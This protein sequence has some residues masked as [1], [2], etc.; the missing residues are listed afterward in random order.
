MVMERMTFVTLSNGPCRVRCNCKGLWATALAIL[1]RWRSRITEPV[2]A[3]WLC[4]V[5]HGNI[6]HVMWS[7]VLPTRDLPVTALQREGR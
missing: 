6:E 1:H 5:R 4:I 3:E 2:C 7:A